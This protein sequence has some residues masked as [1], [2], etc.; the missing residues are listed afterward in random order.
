MNEKLEKMTKEE[1][2]EFAK[3]KWLECDKMSNDIWMNQ[4]NLEK[5]L[6]MLR[7]LA[8]SF[9]F[10]DFDPYKAV[11]CGQGVDKSK[12]AYQCWKFAYEFKTYQQFIRIAFDYCHEALKKEK[13][14]SN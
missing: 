4:D 12:E 11:A 9:D 5:A 10:E 14:I 8:D 2:K 1:L 13:E 6:T 7:E 3:Q